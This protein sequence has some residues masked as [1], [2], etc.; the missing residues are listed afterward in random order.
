MALSTVETCIQGIAGRLAKKYQLIQ[1]NI[2]GGTDLWTRT[3]AAQ[4]ETFENRCNNATATEADART[5]NAEFGTPYWSFLDLLHQY[6]TTDLGLSSFDAYLTAKR[7]RAPQEFAEWWWHKFNA[8]LTPANIVPKF[9]VD[10]LGTMVHGSSFADGAEF[11][12]TVRGHGSIVALLGRIVGTVPGGVTIGAGSWVLTVTCEY[13]DG[14]TYAAT[15]NVANGSVAGTEFEIGTQL[16]AGNEAVGQTV[17]GVA[18]TGQFQEGEK[19][20]IWDANAAEVAEIDT[21]QTNVSLTLTAGILHAY[22]TADGAKVA[23]LFKDVT[24]CITASGGVGGDQLV[25]GV[26]CDRD[27]AL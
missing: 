2:T 26:N 4:D 21:I 22:A 15:V 14:T 6:A 9:D 11:A 17:I 1:A 18:A 25:F 10:Y 7:W 23:P 27:A 5:E 3:D 8:P 12:S 24:A 16:L 20:L 13:S 19:V